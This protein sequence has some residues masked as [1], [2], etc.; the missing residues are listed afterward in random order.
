MDEI[1]EEI[2]NMIK[3]NI[4]VYMSDCNKFKIV[5]QYYIDNNYIKPKVI[6]HIK[7]AELTKSILFELL[8]VNHLYDFR[9]LE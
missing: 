8:M 2:S 5:K 9:E 7:L 1:I 6:E 4:K 3:T